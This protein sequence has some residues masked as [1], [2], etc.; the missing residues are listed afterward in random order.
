MKIF[1]KDIAEK[2]EFTFDGDRLVQKMCVDAEKKIYV[3]E[4]YSGI[5]GRLMGYEVVNGKR[6][7]QPDG[8]IIYRYPSSEEFGS[9]GFFVNRESD[10]DD[11]ISRLK[12]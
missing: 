10:I 9:N 6:Y 3:Y 11:C 12:R 2:K 7:K 1:A 4:R 8:S 5:S